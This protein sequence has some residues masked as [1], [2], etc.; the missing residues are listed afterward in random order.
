MAG[1]RQYSHALGSES[2]EV[3]NRIFKVQ[4]IPLV[5]NSNKRDECIA[6][7]ELEKINSQ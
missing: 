2:Q 5:K 3:V 4:E 7:S 1:L 6:F